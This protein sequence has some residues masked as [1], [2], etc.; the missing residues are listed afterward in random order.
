MTNLVTLFLLIGISGDS[1]FIMVDAFYQVSLPGG[2]TRPGN[3]RIGI[4]APGKPSLRP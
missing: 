2:G 1:I 3:A 4:G